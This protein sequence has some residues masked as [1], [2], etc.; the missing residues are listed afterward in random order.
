[1][2]IPVKWTWN[3]LQSVCR[4]EQET[5]IRN[6]L[7]QAAKQAQ[8]TCWM[9]DYK[10][11]ATM[12]GAINPSREEFLVI[13]M[14]KVSCRMKEVG[15]TSE[16]QRRRLDRWSTQEQETTAGIN[17]QKQREAWLGVKSAQQEQDIVYDAIVQR[18]QVATKEANQERWDRIKDVYGQWDN[19]QKN[20]EMRKN[21]TAAIHLGVAWKSGAMS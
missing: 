19:S 16:R 7:A 12:G 3:K 9:K 18:T 11:M 20:A 15:E 13:S 10:E 8:H 4:K 1:M 21:V 6:G 5:E 14:E 17:E 2:I